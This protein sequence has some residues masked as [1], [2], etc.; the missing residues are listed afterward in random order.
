MRLEATITP[1][2]CPYLEQTIKVRNKRAVKVRGG[3]ITFYTVPNLVVAVLRTV[4]VASWG[5]LT[6][7]TY[8]TKV[9]EI[10]VKTDEVVED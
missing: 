10:R 1:D 9:F 5:S 2:M 7:S 4:P 3:T 8:E 6:R